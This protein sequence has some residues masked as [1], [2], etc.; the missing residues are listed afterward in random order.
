LEIIRKSETEEVAPGDKAAI[1]PKCVFMHVVGKHI[2]A[3]MVE[4]YA[5][6]LGK[7]DYITNTSIIYTNA[8]PYHSRTFN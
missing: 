6:D 3:N 7:V 1:A 5:D 4:F 2:M 8:T